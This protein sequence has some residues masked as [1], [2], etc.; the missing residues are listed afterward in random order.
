MLSPMKL[1]ADKTFS[2]THRP[3]RHDA[4][5]RVDYVVY[6]QGRKIIII[7]DERKKQT[8]TKNEKEN[9]IK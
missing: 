3:D 2:T 6:F 5:F 1:N 7:S 9:E 8:T 4:I